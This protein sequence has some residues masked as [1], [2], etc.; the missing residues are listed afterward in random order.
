MSSEKYLLG[1]WIYIGL[2]LR[3]ERFRIKI[4]I[5]ELAFKFVIET[6][7]I[8]VKKKYTRGPMTYPRKL[9]H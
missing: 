4:E 5:W 1:R 9:Q 2:V 3:G 6:K 8:G 7:D